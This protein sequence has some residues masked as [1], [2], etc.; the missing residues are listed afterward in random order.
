MAVDKLWPA[1]TDVKSKLRNV[2]D[3]RNAYIHEGK[4]DDIELYLYD[5]AR[6]RNLVELWIL[7][8]LGCPDETINLIALENVM[9]IDRP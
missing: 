9:P 2:I 1:G 7:K 4:F 8:L 6:L 5:F 3:R